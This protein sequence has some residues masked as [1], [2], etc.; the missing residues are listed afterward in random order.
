[1]TIYLM[2]YKGKFKKCKL[3]KKRLTS[4][5][6]WLAEKTISYGVKYG[7]S[8]NIHLCGSC[9]TL[10]GAFYAQKRSFQKKIIFIEKNYLSFPSFF[11]GHIRHFF[12]HF[13]RKFL[14]N[15][16]QLPVQFWHP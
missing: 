1:M 10:F 6:L 14:A 12:R 13:D 8:V 5:N 9:V 4:L 11:S 15:Q 2:I 3:H 16:N 7:Q